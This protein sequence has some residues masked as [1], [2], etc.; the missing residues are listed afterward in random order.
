MKVPIPADWN[1]KDWECYRVQFPKSDAFLS[2]FFGLLSQLSRGRFWDETTGSVKDAQVIGWE[3]FTRN[4][5]LNPCATIPDDSGDDGDSGGC[6]G[7]VDWYPFDGRSLDYLSQ[8]E[9]FMSV[10]TGGYWKDGVLYFKYG[11]CCSK[12]VLDEDDPGGEPPTV[13]DMVNG[14]TVPDIDEQLPD[15]EPPSGASFACL[16]ATALVKTFEDLLLAG[17]TI[18]GMVN[19]YEWDGYLQQQLPY[20]SLT[21][22]ECAKLGVAFQAMERLVPLSELTWSAEDTE[23]AICKLVPA[24]NNDS[25]AMTSAEFDAFYNTVA[26]VGDLLHYAQYTALA[27]M[28]DKS[29]YRRA[30]AKGV[31]A[32][33]ANCDCPEIPE[34]PQVPYDLVHFTGINYAAAPGGTPT[35]VLSNY[36]CTATV[37]VDGGA[38]ASTHFKEH[39]LKLYTARNLAIPIKKVIFAYV[40]RPL[41]TVLNTADWNTHTGELDYAPRP[42]IGTLE[43]N[44]YKTGRTDII[45]DG[46]VWSKWG[47]GITDIGWNYTVTGVSF[48]GRLNPD[49]YTGTF[50]YELHIVSVNGVRTGAL[51]GADI[52]AGW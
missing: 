10:V 42:S 37:T 15:F 40:P 23:W 25:L 30:I 24:M 31:F 46:I 36:G 51:S 32:S 49:N 44:N 13:G 12:P 43:T 4:V 19:A 39:S 7:S 45:Q 2:I 35:V 8:E 20:L 41:P 3:I 18:V 5:A 28:I 27:H 33:E 38:N 9:N 16:K 34:P 6:G 1:G 50:V 14:E 52:P 21:N 47:D 29:Q 11:E 22:W 17:Q 26:N 48:G